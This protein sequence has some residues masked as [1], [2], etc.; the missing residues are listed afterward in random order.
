VAPQAG[1]AA[2]EVAPGEVE[3]ALAAR[4]P[5]GA[6]LLVGPGGTPLRRLLVHGGRHPGPQ[7]RVAALAGGPQDRGDGV[8]RGGHDARG[9]GL[10]LALVERGIPAADGGVDVG[11]GDAV[12]VERAPQLDSGG[13]PWIPSSG[14]ATATASSNGGPGAR[15]AG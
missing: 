3:A 10:D 5:P 6:D 12:L 11:E 9:E 4:H 1:T 15:R 7:H 13:R 2:R 8:V 14:R